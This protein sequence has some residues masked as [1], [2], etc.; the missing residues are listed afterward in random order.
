MKEKPYST[1][2]KSPKPKL[3]F[4]VYLDGE[5]Y[6]TSAYNHQGAISNAA[7]RYAEDNDEEVRKVMWQIKEGILDCYVEDREK[8]EIT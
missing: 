7:Y 5:P 3:P 6:H 4:I 1:T 2:P 8:G